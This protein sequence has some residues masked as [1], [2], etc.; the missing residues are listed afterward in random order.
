MSTEEH[1]Q[2]IERRMYRDFAKVLRDH[3]YNPDEGC[4]LAC[5]TDIAMMNVE[6]L[7]TKDHLDD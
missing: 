6:D 2:D 1:A 7:L 3:G 4:L 5:L